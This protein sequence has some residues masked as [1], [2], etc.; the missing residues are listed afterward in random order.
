MASAFQVTKGAMTNTIKRLESRELIDV[1]P[2]PEDGRGKLVR[3][4]ENGKEMH[5]RCIETLAPELENLQRHFSND[6]F[7]E[8]LPHLQELRQYLDENR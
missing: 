4:N 7:A 1:I 2:D 6:Q 3:L 5:Q 8:L